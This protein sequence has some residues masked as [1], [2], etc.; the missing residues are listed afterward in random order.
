MN[1]FIVWDKKS[2][3]FRVVSSI[4]YDTG[5]VW[6][7]DKEKIDIKLVNLWGQPFNDDGEQNPD[8][9]VQREPKDFTIHR[10]IGKTD[11]ENNKIYAD[12][13][14]VEFECWEED[15]EDGTEIN[16]NENIICF[17]T[18][19]KDS[20]IYNLVDIESNQKISY[21]YCSSDFRNPKIIDTIQ[22]NK[23]GLIKAD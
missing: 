3:K 12:S 7:I 20:L 21:E 1:E 10:Y 11:I 17:L 2:K 19:D 4:V 23:H 8:I 9:L 22:E 16:T 15:F 5:S 6:D 14:I 18:Y 13:S